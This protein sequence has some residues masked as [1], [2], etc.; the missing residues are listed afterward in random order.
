MEHHCIKYIGYWIN[1]ILVIGCMYA[2][3]IYVSSYFYLDYYAQPC[4]LLVSIITQNKISLK[5]ILY[6]NVIKY[7]K[8][9]YIIRSS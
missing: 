3:F 9:Q 4:W 7:N 1:W 6:Y 8:I 2:K 5:N